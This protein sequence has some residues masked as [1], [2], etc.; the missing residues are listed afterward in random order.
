VMFVWPFIDAWIRRKLR[1]I[2]WRQWKEPRTRFRK[3]QDLGVN[4]AKAAHAAWGRDG[5]WGSSMG[6]AINVALPNRTLR[7]M[8]LVNLIEQH[9]RLADSA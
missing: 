4:R 5:P 1:A 6:S 9:R 8:G 7:G 3:L 2:I